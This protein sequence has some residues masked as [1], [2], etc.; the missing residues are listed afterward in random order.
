MGRTFSRVIVQE[1]ED[2]IDEISEVQTSTTDGG[3]IVS[4]VITGVPKI[5][6]PASSGTANTFGSWAAYDASTS[7]ISYVCGVTIGMPARGK[8]IDAQVDI[9]VSESAIVSIPFNY[10]YKSDVGYLPPVIVTFPI[11][12][13]VAASGAIAVRVSDNEAN[14][15]TYR[16][17]LIYYQNL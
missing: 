8:T 2:K 11:P 3:T 6:T 14:A 12:I 10:F 9:G 1:I 17:G 7:A 16:V 15:N 13:K 5:V 4:D